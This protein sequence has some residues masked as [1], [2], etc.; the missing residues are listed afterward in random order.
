[1]ADN[2][3]LKNRVKI[4]FHHTGD[5]YY[6]E[7][8]NKNYPNRVFIRSLEGSTQ[9]TVDTHCCDPVGLSWEELRKK[10]GQELEKAVEKGGVLSAKHESSKANAATKK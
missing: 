4:K 8:F 9:G 6:F 1:M 5:E 10:H 2:E 3:E 7:G